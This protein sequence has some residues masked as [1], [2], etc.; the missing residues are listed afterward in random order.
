MC[1]IGM[2]ES[3]LGKSQQT[4]VPFEKRLS[5]VVSHLLRKTKGHDKDT[6]TP[7]IVKYLSLYPLHVSCS[8][9]QSVPFPDRVGNAHGQASHETNSSAA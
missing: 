3:L 8:L 4:K 7:G 2:T 6:S 1:A 9:S 5:H